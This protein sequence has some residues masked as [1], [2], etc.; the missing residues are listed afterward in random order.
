MAAGTIPHENHE[1]SP[2]IPATVLQ[3]VDLADPMRPAAD[4]DPIQLHAA[5]NE[6]V[7]FALQATSVFSRRPLFA[8]ISPL[9]SA[10]GASIGTDRLNAYQILPMPVTVNPGYVRQSG[11]N[12][13]NRSAAGIAAPGDERWAH[14]ARFA[15]RSHATHHPR[16]TSQRRDDPP[17]GWNCA[18][19]RI[20]RRQFTRARVIWS[21]VRVNPS[22]AEFP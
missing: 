6:W 1:N 16:R 8:H 11:V 12:S 14:F 19:R 5:R 21:M 10:G 2:I 22:V 18:F 17:V 13:A 20:S 3:S 15:A 7:S 4:S 9:T